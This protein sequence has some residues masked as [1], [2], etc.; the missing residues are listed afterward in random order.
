MK[1]TTFTLVLAIS[2]IGMGFGPAVV[3]NNTAMT[4]ST[5]PDTSATTASVTDNPTPLPVFAD[6]TNPFYS[7]SA[8]YLQAPPFDRIHESDYLP[9]FREAMRQAQEEIRQ[10]ADNPEPATFENTIAALERSGAMLSR[11]NRAFDIASS[12]NISDYI[13]KVDA[14]V[15]PLLAQHADSITLDA[16][17]FARIHHLYEQREKL[18]LDAVAKRLVERHHLKFVRGGALLAE[19]DKVTLRALNEEASRLTTRYSE[20]LLKDTNASAVVVETVAELDG[21]SPSDIA[22]AAAA[23]TARGLKD[24]WVFPLLN[25]TTQPVL[26]TLKNRA[27]RERIYRA[28]VERC[29]R[30]GAHDTRAIIA[31]LAQLRAQKAELLGFPTNADYVLG[32]QMAKNPQAALALLGRVGPAA[33]DQARREIAD[34][35]AVIDREKGGFALEPWDWAYYAEKV[36]KEKYDLDESQIRPY[37]ELDHVLIDGIFFA[38]NRLYGITCKQ[39]LDIPVFHP[40]V[41]VW[42]VF[43]ADGSTIGLIYFDFYARESKKGGAWMSAL[44]N[45]SELLGTKPV[46]VNVLNI[47]KPA[48]GQ[49]ALLSFDEVITAFHEFGHG[50]HGLFSQVKY[51]TMAGTSTPRDFVEFPSQFNENWAL[52]PTV[53]ANYAKHYQTGEPMPAELVEKLKRSSA[54]NQGYDTLEYVQAALIDMEWNALPATAL[55]QDPVTFEQAALAKHQVDLPQVPPR[56]HSWY[57]SH[58]WSSG[59]H[60]GYYAY[61]WTA[62]LGADSYAWFNERGGMTPANGKRYRDGILSR[63]GTMDAHEL[64]LNFRGKEAVIEPLLK[65]RGF[66]VSASK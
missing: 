34:L 22:A 60:A 32:D 65:Q 44:V 25:T 33:A 13:Q 54:F 35:Q 52:E 2:L 59:Y 50:L 38:A 46:I 28:S 47:P 41:R 18:G 4:K 21:L 45:Q 19:A 10:I 48:I 31:R 7:P 49:P 12:T 36:R 27:L 62:V 42:E 53:L 15:S 29:R 43:N 1:K 56:Y 57:F 51:P 37:F 61:L 6:S 14:E 30:G 58:I 23:A 20:F 9:A 17:L 5:T 16:K 55:L 24:K 26:A 64:Y 40:D 3:G 11:V 39:R 8:L 66:P 63:G